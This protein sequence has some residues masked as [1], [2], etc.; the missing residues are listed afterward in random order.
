MAARPRYDSAERAPNSSKFMED[1]AQRESFA[2][3]S[4]A[5]VCRSSAQAA[6]DAL[7]ANNWDIERAISFLLDRAGNDAVQPVPD[8][9]VAPS[10]LSKPLNMSDRTWKAMLMAQEEADE[11]DAMRRLK[12]EVRCERC[13][14]L[15]HCGWRVCLPTPNFAYFMP[16]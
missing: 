13:T 8:A 6:R 5:G 3:E 4:V 11:A 2:V 14:L 12:E 16:I 1:P 9:R 10:R 15:G 7:V